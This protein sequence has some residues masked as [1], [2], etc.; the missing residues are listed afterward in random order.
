VWTARLSLDGSLVAAATESGDVC[1]WSTADGRETARL[2]HPDVSVAVAISP[3]AK[4]IATG[5]W[6]A[7]LRIFEVDGSGGVNG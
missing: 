3:N 1:L 5:G 4:T 2:A 6:D 7:Y